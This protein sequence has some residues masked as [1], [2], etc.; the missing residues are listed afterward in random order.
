MKPPNTVWLILP[1]A[2]MLEWEWGDW[3]SSGSLV[4]ALDL[5]TLIQ[6]SILM[7]VSLSALS[8]HPELSIKNFTV[9]I[10]RLTKYISICKN[11]AIC[12][13]MIPD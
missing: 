12:C 9:S 13:N 3:R 2:T 6:S 10:T 1:I 11:A 7:E 5:Q 8:L 4:S